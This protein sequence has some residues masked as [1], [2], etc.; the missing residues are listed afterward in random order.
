MV[1]GA[2]N[3]LNT[4]RE[5]QK[6]SVFGNSFNLE[7]A[8]SI[9]LIESFARHHARDELVW[10]MRKLEESQNRWIKAE[11]LLIELLNFFGWIKNRKKIRQYFTS[12][13]LPGNDDNGDEKGIDKT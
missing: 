12:F 5:K 2:E 9:K 13:F 10:I 8:Q 7:H 3:L 4:L 11:L 1:L 6:E